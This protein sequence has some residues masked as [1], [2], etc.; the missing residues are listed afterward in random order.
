[1][2]TSASP[3]DWLLEAHNPSVRYFALTELLGA[4]AG[5]PDV[6]QA[7]AAIMSAEPVSSILALQQPGGHWGKAD[8]FYTEKYGGTVWQLLVLA[9]LGADGSD[10]RLRRAAEFLFEHSQEREHGGFAMNRSAKMGG[11]RMTEV[12]PCLTGNMVWAL[13][14][15]GYAGDPRLQRAVDWITTYQ[16]FDDGIAEPPSGA[17][18]YR[19]EICFGRHSCHMGVVKALKGL[20]ALPSAARTPVVAETIACGTEFML[21]HRVHK[22]SHD[23][24][25][26]SKPGWLKFA[27]PQMYQTDVLEVLDV[28]TRLGCVADERL[29]EALEVVRSKQGA[30]GRWRLEASFNDRMPVAVE[31]KGQ[32]SK[33]ITLRA[34]TVLQRCGG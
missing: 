3:L 20:A 1:M 21:A 31:D 26:V 34:M 30:D 13:A 14:H 28:L 23:L 11:G 8:G 29:S 33:W 18:Y 27:F 5:D 15:L 6:E 22:R 4:P 9:E 25:R 24:R 2:S 7:R 32:P 12:I 10:P 19:Y 16:R 17:P